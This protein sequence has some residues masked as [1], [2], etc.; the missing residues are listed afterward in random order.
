MPSAHTTQVA[1]INELFVHEPPAHVAQT[2]ADWV[3]LALWGNQHEAYE[4]HSPSNLFIV[5][6]ASADVVQHQAD[7]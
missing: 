5:H 2:Q 7:R 3:L 1:L 4:D 6:E